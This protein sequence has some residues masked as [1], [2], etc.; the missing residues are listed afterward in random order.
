MGLLML[1]SVSAYY[2]AVRD[3]TFVPAYSM[4]GIA[5]GRQVVRSMSAPPKQV[6]SDEVR[7]S[8]FR[9][10]TF[11]QAWGIQKGAVV[12]KRQSMPVTVSFNAL[13][14]SHISNAPQ[15]DINPLNRRTGPYIGRYGIEKEYIKTMS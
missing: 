10:V 12:P 9:P 2:V 15:R 8:S 5:A 11:Y 3:N 6:L 4:V 7:G 1:S 13:S 14:S